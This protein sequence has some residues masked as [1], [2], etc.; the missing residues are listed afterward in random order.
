MRSAIGRGVFWRR[1][2]DVC[3]ALAALAL[4][5]TSSAVEAQD[6]VAPEAPPADYQRLVDQAVGEFGAAHWAE[7]RA[8]FDQAHR[9]YPNARTLRG[10]GMAAFELRD[11]AASVRY[12]SAALVEDTI[13]LTEEQRA[14]V[15]ELLG[16]AQGFVGQF[17]IPAAP[18][19]ARLVVDGA[20]TSLPG[21]PEQPAPLLLSIDSHTIVIRTASGRSTEV[22]VQVR[23]RED[24][25]L[26]IDMTPLAPPPEPEPAPPE[27]TP[28][29]VEPEPS[30]PIIADPPEPETPIAPYIVCGVGGAVAVTGLILF[31]VGRG[32]VD[33]VESASLGTDWAELSSAYNRAP[34]LTGMGATFMGIGA[35]TVG[36]SVVWI[37]SSSDDDEEPEARVR[38]RASR[39]GASIAIEGTF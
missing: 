31:L 39:S 7:A 20:A 32:D 5:V 34:V 26:E 16:R 1:K 19:D 25:T 11:Y 38:A 8:L 14:Q 3:S 35:A 17:T 37:L 18:A 12:L 10:L 4:L 21:W 30:P 24:T 36:A 27:P 2:R 6:A 23:G 9:V 33:T 29:P 22:R 28:P 13:P 15:T